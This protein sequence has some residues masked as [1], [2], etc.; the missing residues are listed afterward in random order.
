MGNKSKVASKD[1]EKSHGEEEEQQK[2]EN[3]EDMDA[4]RALLENLLKLSFDQE[5]VMQQ[6]K[7]IDI[8]NPLDSSTVPDVSAGAGPLGRSLMPMTFSLETAG[9]WIT[10]L[11]LPVKPE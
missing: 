10:R 11:A 6:L 4:L 8:N 5:Q 1:V 3:E 2:E 9:L 7:S